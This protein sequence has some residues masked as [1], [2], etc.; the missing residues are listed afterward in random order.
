MGVEV[1]SP[2]QLKIPGQGSLSA[3]I[4]LRQLP[5]KRSNGRNDSCF[6]RCLWQASEQ[7]SAVEFT[8]I[9]VAAGGQNVTVVKKGCSMVSADIVHGARRHPLAGCGVIVAQ[10]A[11]GVVPFEVT[12]FPPT[13]GHRQNL[14]GASP[15]NRPWVIRERGGDRG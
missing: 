4:W 10:L 2:L 15:R 1:T 12:L 3:D 8:A 6:A 9:V 5:Q 7:F 14:A 11:S 13:T